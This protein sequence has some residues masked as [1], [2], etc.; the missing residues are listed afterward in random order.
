VR[1]APTPRGRPALRLALGLALSLT[2][3]LASLGCGG[4][5]PGGV[6]SAGTSAGADADL[7][8]DAV[9]DP[10]AGVG[11]PTLQLYAVLTADPTAMQG[12]PALA[13]MWQAVAGQGPRYGA[14]RRQVE[15][16]PGDYKLNVDLDFADLPHPKVPAKAFE[17]LAAQLPPAAA[18]Q[19][20]AAKLAIFFR[21]DAG[22]LPGGDHISLPAAPSPPRRSTPSW[23]SPASPTRCRPGCRPGPMARMP[24]GC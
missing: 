2:P 1:R 4:A 22:L 9:A 21:S 20:R 19:A 16:A 17:A 24:A 8:T 15:W 10:F 23:R 13:G 6:G 12:E 14:V 11:R 5:R 3:G 18:A 7:D